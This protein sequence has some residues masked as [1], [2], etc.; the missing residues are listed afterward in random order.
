M[1]IVQRGRVVVVLLL[2]AVEVLECVQVVMLEVAVAAVVDAEAEGAEGAAEEGV[3]E[4][5]EEGE[6]EDVV[7]VVEEG[8]VELSFITTSFHALDHDRSVN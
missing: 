7:V 6:E 3:E 1:G 4:G 8:A 2:G 5:V